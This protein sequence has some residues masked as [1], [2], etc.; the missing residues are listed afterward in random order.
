MTVDPAPDRQAPPPPASG[1]RHLNEE[2]GFK[3]YL[4][5]EAQ[6][7]A[8]LQDELKKALA[9]FEND[10]RRKSLELLRQRGIEFSGL[11]LEL[12][13]GTCWFSSEISKSASVN[14]VV[15]LDFARSILSRM[16][17][18][19]MDHASADTARI[20]R[21]VGDFNRLP[22]SEKAFDFVVMDAA[23][24]HAIRTEAVLE[25]ICRVL[26]DDG[27]F[28]AIRE[29]VLPLWRQNLR[30]KIGA[31]ERAQ[32]VTENIFSRKE[33]RAFFAK[34]SLD[35]RFVPTRPT[36]RPA[37]WQRLKRLAWFLSIPWLNPYLFG[38]YYFLAKKRRSA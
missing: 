22:F 7:G 9:K 27:R 30:N 18:L 37:R 31:Q 19:V 1:R 24:H 25:E 29:P 10:G 21:V 28:L 38:Y 36:H 14:H 5:R 2:T 15:A 35:V 4:F 17:P 6:L 26:K 12:G 3:E 34:A 32:G 16:A 23:L 13:A 20:Q 8:D 33:W 11:V